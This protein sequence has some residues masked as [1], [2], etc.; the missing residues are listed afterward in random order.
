MVVPV[1][2]AVGSLYP[3]FAKSASK[4][5]FLKAKQRIKRRR[6]GPP[7]AALARRMSNREL[8]KRKATIRFPSLCSP[9]PLKIRTSV[10]LFGMQ[11]VREG[12]HLAQGGRDGDWPGALGKR[13][14]RL[15]FERNPLSGPHSPESHGP[16]GA[17]RR[18]RRSPFI[19]T[20]QIRPRPSSDPGTALPLPP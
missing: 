5:A 20:S 11:S 12:S 6:A 7:C 3:F 19:W 4:T 8:R 2:R 1:F 16:R 17:G 18:P 14:G 10:A 9:N 15:G 13:K